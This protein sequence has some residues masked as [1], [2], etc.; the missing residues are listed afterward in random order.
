MNI[1][2]NR[3]PEKT[4]SKQGKLVISNVLQSQINALHQAVGKTE[5]CGVLI[6]SEQAGSINDPENLI[7]RGEGLYLMDIGT[8][9]YT[10]AEM[11]DSILDVYDQFPKTDPHV[12][13]R[14]KWRTGM[15]HTHHSMNV[16]FSGT[17]MDEL[18]DNT[19]HHVYYLSLIVNFNSNEWKA[20]V[21]YIGD[22]TET[23]EI[24]GFR[25]NKKLKSVNTTKTMFMIDM[26][27]VFQTQLWFVDRYKEVKED[28]KKRK[29]EEA[30]KRTVGVGGYPRGNYGG[31]GFHYGAWGGEYGTQ[32]LNKKKETVQKV[33]STGKTEEK[34]DELTKRFLGSWLL[35]TP[36]TMPKFNQEK[37]VEISKIVKA[38]ESNITEG[39]YDKYICLLLSILPN[40]YLTYFGK[41]P[42]KDQFKFNLIM[43]DIIEF[44]ENNKGVYP[45]LDLLCNDLEYYLNSEVIYNLKED[46]EKVSQ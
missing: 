8:E 44:F 39:S 12:T 24:T 3:L 11:K 22:C 45:I 1:T 35:S 32:H 2:N 38:I 36:A 33:I 14:N 5:W 10:E 30:R 42:A 21:A 43:E 6:F 26:N 17:D 31:A 29:E 37:P 19:P 20:K 27:V 40:V 18:R 23:V 41:T 25:R 15:I 28:C 4:V 13:K 46:D 34:E 7:L 9:A 16:F